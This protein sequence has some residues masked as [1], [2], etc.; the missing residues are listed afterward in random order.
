[1]LILAASVEKGSEHPLGKAIVAEAGVRGLDLYDPEDFKAS[2]GLGVS[3]VI[4]D[5][6]PGWGNPAGSRNLG[7]SEY[8]DESPRFRHRGKP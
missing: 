7:F 2:G 8:R 6:R 4:R 3:A 1:M 5:K